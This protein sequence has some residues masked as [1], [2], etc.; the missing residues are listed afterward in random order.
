MFARR[1]RQARGSWASDAIPLARSGSGRARDTSGIQESRPDED[2]SDGSALARSQNAT[3]CQPQPT[4]RPDS[5]LRER[6]LACRNQA[7][8]NTVA[9]DLDTAKDHR[10]AGKEDQ[11]EHQLTDRGTAHDPLAPASPDDLRRPLQRDTR[12]DTLQRDHRQ[13]EEARRAPRQVGQ[14]ADQSRD[15]VAR[16]S[17]I[18]TCTNAI[19]APTISCNAAQP[20]IAPSRVR[21]T[22]KPSPVVV[23]SPSNDRAA[24]ALGATLQKL[25]ATASTYT[26]TTA[27]AISGACCACS[28][29]RS[30][31]DPAGPPPSSP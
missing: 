5:E 16:R 14:A 29:A 10:P 6:S 19:R 7:S 18:S 12:S 22:A 23:S 24:Q 17:R 20:R 3:A 4:T 11:Q 15:Q 2:Q 27:T 1:C 30:T 9:M 26:P 21:A 13:H 28:C 31:R 8:F 25:Q